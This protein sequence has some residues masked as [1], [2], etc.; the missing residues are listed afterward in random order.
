MDIGD[1]FQIP[2]D[3]RLWLVR[4]IDRSTNTAFTVSNTGEQSTWYLEE[5]H[6][7]LCNVTI[8]WPSVT[9]PPRRGRLIQVC[10]GATPLTPIEHWV[11]LDEFQMGGSLYLNPELALS[12]GARLTI[13]SDKRRYTV[14]VGR[15]FRPAGQK[16][17][18]QE[19]ARAKAA[20]EAKRTH[21]LYDHLLDDD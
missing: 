20:K 6:K 8:D 15:D 11:K 16:R 14:D 9:L 10:V 3:E 21:S 2:G 13:V 19:E 17:K 12:F 1:L 4:K 7:H 5:D 18:E